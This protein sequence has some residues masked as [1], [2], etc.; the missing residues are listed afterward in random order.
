MTW[1]FNW[2]FSSTAPSAS[3]RPQNPRWPF[4]HNT[5]T[6]V[7]NRSRPYWIKAGDTM[8][9]LVGRIVG[10]LTS[11]SKGPPRPC[12]Q[13]RWTSVRDVPVFGQTSV[14]GKPSAAAGFTTLEKA[15]SAPAML[16]PP[17]Y[18]HELPRP[19][20]A[21]GAPERFAG[22]NCGG[23]LRLFISHAKDRTGL[24]LAGLA[25]K[26]QIDNRKLA[27]GFFTIGRPTFH[28]GLATWQ[29]GNW[30]RGGWVLSLI[31]H[32]CATEVLRRPLLVQTG[33]ALGQTSMR[34]PLRSLLEAPHL[35]WIIRGRR[36][37]RSIVSPAV[38]NFPME[39]LSADSLPRTTR[40]APV[41]FFSCAAVETN[42]TERRFYP[43]AAEAARSFPL[44][45]A[46]R[47]SYEACRVFDRFKGPHPATPRP[48]ILYPGPGPLRAG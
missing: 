10:T 7:F 22:R 42:E 27:E 26:H 34:R 21:E 8:W 48:S 4:C 2:R 13:L 37:F 30:E 1:V 3:Y 12:W 32:A 46:C 25:L 35:A 20:L 43:A 41:S 38:P 6:V 16:A 31:N 23:I 11:S 9:G 17:V 36:A 24:P 15:Q 29:K 18:W 19:E 14:F 39:N 28:P 45:R 40:R 33:S 44:R 47:H 5:V